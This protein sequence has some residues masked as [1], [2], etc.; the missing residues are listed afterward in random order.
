MY[1]VGDIKNA[2]FVDG[3]T[4]ALGDEYR[5][6]SR[7]GNFDVSAYFIHFDLGYNLGDAKITYRFWYASGDDDPDDDEFNGFWQQMLIFLIVLL[8][9]KGAIQM[10]ITFLKGLML[11]IKVL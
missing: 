10:M 3:F 5:F 11:W 6:G 2:N 7:S 8:Y 4:N 9:L 1:Q